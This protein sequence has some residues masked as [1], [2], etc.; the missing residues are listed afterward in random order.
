V[1][2]D[3]HVYDPRAQLTKTYVMEYPGTSQAEGAAVTA[4]A[5]RD[6]RKK[7]DHILVVP[8]HETSGRSESEA[9]P[10]KSHAQIKREVDEVLAKGNV[11][12]EGGLRHY[13]VGHAGSCGTSACLAQ[14]ERGKHDYKAG[15]S[16]HST[17]VT[18]NYEYVVYP[19]AS[20]RNAERAVKVPI[21]RG[22]FDLTDAKHEA[23]QM[24]TPAAIYSVSKGR[25]VGYVHPSGR[26]VTFR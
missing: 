12:D 26:Y 16:G 15:D 24:G 11:P 2:W 1:K 5:S 21:R 9:Q 3:V 17:I 25:F 22:T 13:H 6:L 19:E 18:R 10:K 7:M 23:K 4:Y 14:A 20:H 8:H